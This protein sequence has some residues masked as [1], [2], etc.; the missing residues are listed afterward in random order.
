MSVIVTE[1]F[2][3]IP[4]AK[5]VWDLLSKQTGASASI[6]GATQVRAGAVRP[7]IIVFGDKTKGDKGSDIANGLSVGARVRIIRVPWFG[8]VG[9]VTELPSK[10]VKI[11]TGA[12]A[13][14]LRVKLESGEN[15][16]VPRANVELY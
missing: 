3:K 16:I 8:R 6:N 11:E 15:V 12:E 5:R 7:E 4:M 10:M 1:G 13:R 14:I 9:E 2:G